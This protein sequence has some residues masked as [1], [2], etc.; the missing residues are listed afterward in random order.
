MIIPRKLLISGA[1]SPYFIDSNAGS[2]SAS[3][4]SRTWSHTTTSDTTC[5]VVGTFAANNA[6]TANVTGVTYNGVSLT[7]VVKSAAGSGQGGL[8]VMFNPP[9]GTYNVVMTASS[10]DRG[11]AGNSAN[12]GGVSAVNVSGN[13]A[14]ASTDPRTLTI[15]STAKGL[16][17]GHKIILGGNSTLHTVTASAPTGMAEER[18]NK[19]VANSFAKYQGLFY[20]DT[21]VDAGSTSFTSDMTGGSMGTNSSQYMILT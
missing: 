6:K 19:F 17:V 10:G 16:P 7:Q 20:S 3:A 9:V 12:F 21:L 5:L 13:A 18:A 2:N 11:I 4:T 1:V 8:W 15:T 14:L